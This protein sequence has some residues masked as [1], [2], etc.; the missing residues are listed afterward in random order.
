MKRKI[1]SFVY[2]PLLKIQ[3]YQ[4]EMIEAQK[5]PAHL[6]LSLWHPRNL[7]TV[8]KTMY[9]HKTSFSIK[10]SHDICN[11]EKWGKCTISRLKW[12]FHLKIR[13]KSWFQWVLKH[14]CF[15]S[16]KITLNGEIKWHFFYKERDFLIQEKTTFYLSTLFEE[17]TT[18]FSTFSFM[19]FF[20][21]N[22]C[23]LFVYIRISFQICM[24]FSLPPLL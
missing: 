16:H 3:G 13:R 11:K 1:N 19:P 17:F 8:L 2:P 21:V 20:V 9:A 24:T 4:A 22:K 12:S 15:Q 5:S 10:C 23:N 7:Y 18:D 6:I 14:D